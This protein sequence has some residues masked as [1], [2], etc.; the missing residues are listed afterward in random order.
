M[1]ENAASS[2]SEENAISSAMTRCYE[3]YIIVD[4]GANLTNKK[5]S[6]DLDS[7]IQRAK[8]AGVQKI[9]VTGASIRSSKE[10]LRL[11]RIYPGT[12][13]STAGVHPHDAKSWENPDTLQ[14]LESI[15]TNPECVAIG[16]CGLDYNRDFSDPETQR[17]VFHKQVELACQLN[18]PLI[19]H[20]RAAQAD[21]L[22]VLSHYKNRLPPVL[23]HS[24][25]GTAEEAQIYLDQGFY[26]GITGY[27]CK[28]KSDS[29]I[30]QLLEAGQ[31]P[32]DKILVETDAP[33]MYPN[34]RASKLPV[35]VKDA[36]TE[37][38]MTFLHRY[39]TFQRNEPCALPAI[40]EMVAAF[41]QTTPEEV[42]LATA[43]NALKLFG[44]N[45]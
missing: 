33:F 37:R 42:A 7:V 9:M 27:L 6:R 15:A 38:S 43:F 14:E 32:L 10:A 1:A 35:R 16:E 39:C 19:I 24:F 26:L 28:D 29:G 40:V 30:R 20:E 41:M 36:L 5:Y 44:L 12:L 45:A 11:T 22:E 8:D 34:T 21:V 18:K 31:A 23:I 4:V 17:T 25:I 3:N 2:N 13:Y